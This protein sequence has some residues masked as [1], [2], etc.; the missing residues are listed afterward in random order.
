[1]EPV[2]APKPNVQLLTDRQLADAELRTDATVTRY[3]S[4][5]V[6]PW[7]HMPAREKR[8]RWV[9]AWSMF[10]ATAAA[11]PDA[12]DTGVRAML[13]ASQ[14]EC[15]ELQRDLPT[16]FRI[17][18][19]RITPPSSVH[20]EFALA[21]REWVLINIKVQE[22]VSAG[23]LDAATAKAKLQGLAMARNMRPIQPGELK[24]ATVVDMDG[25][26][27]KAGYDPSELNSKDSLMDR[28]RREG[29]RIDASDRMHSAQSMLSKTLQSASADTSISDAEASAA[30]AAKNAGMRP[31]RSAM[32]A[33]LRDMLQDKDSAQV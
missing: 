23:L 29:L 11:N 21:Q 17:S 15:A 32:H 30:A 8:E 13:V 10:D 2:T 22:Q 12:P 20:A 19:A 26:L 5:R 9:R 18:M 3:E 31:G 27:K 25:M 1:V 24:G 16:A 14:E 33:A 28:M 6:T 4:T 7:K